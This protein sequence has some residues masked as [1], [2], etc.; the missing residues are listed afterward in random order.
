MAKN[1]KTPKKPL[2]NYNFIETCTSM[3]IKSCVAKNLAEAE[4][5]YN[6]GRADLDSEEVQHNVLVEISENGAT[7]WKHKDHSIPDNGP[8]TSQELSAFL[9]D[10]KTKAIRKYTQ[11]LKSGAIDEEFLEKGSY[12]IAHCIIAITAKLYGPVTK[13]GKALLSNLE[14]FV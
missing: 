6:D 10:F 7:I 11:A 3:P 2:N 8:I 14:K 1:G 13:D 5:M 9:D 4:K 12:A